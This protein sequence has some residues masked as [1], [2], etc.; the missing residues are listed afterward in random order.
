MRLVIDQID[1]T[2]GLNSINFSN[3]YKHIF[4]IKNQLIIEERRRNIMENMINLETFA[5]GALAEKVNMA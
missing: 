5:D 2:S 4:S 3:S 1:L